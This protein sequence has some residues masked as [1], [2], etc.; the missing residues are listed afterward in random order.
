VAA[1]SGSYQYPILVDPEWTVWSNVTPGNWQFH[2]WAGYTYGSN[3]GELWMKHVGSYSANDT[4]EWSMT[5]QGVTKIFEMYV[6][7]DM[8][9]TYSGSETGYKESTFPWQVGEIEIWGTGEHEETKLSG[10]PYA[11]EATVCAR[12]DCQPGGV[13]ESNKEG[14][15][16]NTT[17]SGSTPFGGSVSQVSTDSGRHDSGYDLLYSRRRVSCRESRGRVYVLR[18][19]H[20]RHHTYASGRRD[21]SKGMG[22]HMKNGTA[23]EKPSKHAKRD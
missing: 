14:F 8:Y 4:A 11:T 3:G 18:G 6:K 17:E 23:H 16:I 5:T 10:V 7:D 2:E 21:Y 20:S 12:S 13:A 22:Q 19:C 15:E 1:G 9:P